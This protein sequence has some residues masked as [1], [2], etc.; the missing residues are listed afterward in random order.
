LLA[1]NFWVEGTLVGVR[2]VRTFSTW[3]VGSGR[4]RK[5]R[6]RARLSTIAALAAVSLSVVPAV[7]PAVAAVTP[8]APGDTKIAGSDEAARVIA[9]RYH[10]RVAVS[11]ET[12]STSQ[13][14]ALPDGSMQLVSSA[15]PVRV[16]QSGKWVPIS[17]KLAH[18]KDGWLTPAASATP[19]M[20]AP[21]GS[22]VLA[23]V[24]TAKGAWVTEMWPDGT[25]PTPKVVGSSALYQG[26][27]PGVDL[28]LTATASGMS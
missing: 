28:E 25:L 26:V 18:T 16:S 23:R 19:V 9:M 4:S 15:L 1:G 8:T 6:T 10:H 24:Q 7:S 13:V 17:T 22:H 21:G 14:S 2:S 11:A 3:F 12:T 27:F 20:F 5:V